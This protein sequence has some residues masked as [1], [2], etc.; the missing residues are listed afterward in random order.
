M[1]QD[2]LNF[3]TA[4][5][6]YDLRL[7]EQ[8]NNLPNSDITFDEDDNVDLNQGVINMDHKKITNHSMRRSAIQ[9]LTELNVTTDRIMAFSGY[10][11][12]GGVASY[13]TFTNQI[14]NSTVSMII[15]NQDSNSSR[16]PLKSLPVNHTSRPIR[17]KTFKP[18]PFKP[19]DASKPFI[20]PLKNVKENVQ[21]KDQKNILESVQECVQETTS[22]F[23]SDSV[24]DTS[25]SD[26]VES[27]PKIIVEN[28]NNC[29]ID[30]K[31]SFNK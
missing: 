23:N 29:N 3:M 17:S 6:L 2:D 11:S 5:Q 28:C 13:Q 16:L 4:T 19:Y 18:K 24:Q 27:A 10:R 8:I 7:H 30:I 15:P 26:L 14:M 9:I 22:S 20:S 31:V 25:N 1:S 12:I 21:K